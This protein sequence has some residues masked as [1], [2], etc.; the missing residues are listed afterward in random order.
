ML[1]FSPISPAGSLAYATATSS[2]Y[3]SNGSGWYKVTLINIAPSITLSSTT[4]SPSLTNLTLDFTY[5]VTEP[6]GTPTTVSIANSGI[7]TTGNVAITH[8]TSNNHVR[9]VFDGTTEYSSDATVTLSVTD[10][11]NTGTGTITIATAYYESLNTRYNSLLLK[12][13]RNRR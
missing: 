10:G 9:L 6:E 7:A 2:L 11:V 8:T 13:T 4:A 1:P 5:T 3:M 12:A